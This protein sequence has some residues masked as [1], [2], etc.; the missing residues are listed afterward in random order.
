MDAKGGVHPPYEFIGV[1]EKQGMVSM[2]DYEIFRQSCELLTRWRKVWPEF[3]ISVNFSRATIGEPDYLEQV[4][5]IVSETGVRPGQILVEVTEPSQKMQLE[6]I[7]ER[8]S[9]LKERGFSVALDDMGTEASCLE[10]LFLPQ[11]DI[12]KIDRS[13][14]SKS[15]NGQREQAV[16]AG[17]IDICHRLDISCVAEGIETESQLELLGK[18]NCDRIQGYYIGKPMPSGEFFERFAP[19]ENLARGMET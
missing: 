11:L 7:D 9:A 12:V 17:L 8:L 1:M 15:E 5:R 2:V 10:M 19:V 4:D 14:I 16:I 18:L 13:L 3:Y 6:V